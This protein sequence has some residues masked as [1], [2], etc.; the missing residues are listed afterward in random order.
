MLFLFVL[1]CLREGISSSPGYPLTC[2]V[3][4]DDFELL[5]FGLHLPSAG[6]TADAYILLSVGGG[7]LGF[8]VGFFVFVFNYTYCACMMGVCTG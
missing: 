8:F 7:G 4:E 6:R 2:Y 5:I 1:F 3:T